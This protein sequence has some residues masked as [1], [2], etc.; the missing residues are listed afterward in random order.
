MLRF[1][2][3]LVGRPI[4]NRARRLAVEF[5]QQTKRA[6]AFQRE[7]LLSRIARNADSAFGR[8]H[9][10]GE[11]HS[12]EDFRR[13]VPIADYTRHEPYIDRVRNGDVS[14]LFGPGTEVLMF[15]MTSGTTNRPKTI[16]VTREALNNY[17]EGWLIWGIQAFDAH[18]D[19]IENG[20]RPILQIASDWRESYTPAGIPC[21]AI[22]GLTASMQSRMIRTTYCMP[23][24]GSRIK[25]VESKYYVALR[26]SIYK[27]L[28][29]IIAA[30]PSTILN[31]V[32]LGDRERETLIR[33]LHDGT[34]ATRWSIPDDVRRELRFRTRIRR[35]DAA[36][37]LEQIVS[38]TGR[39]LPKDYWPNLEFL[40]NWMGG[41][42]RAYLRG[43]PEF[44]GEKPVRDVGL[45]AS[46]G[47]MTIPIEDNTPAGVLDIRHHYFEFIPEEDADKPDPQ[48]VE[49]VDL[50]EGKNYFV[51]LT[52]AGGLYRY[53][54]FDL[55]R[56]V[57]FHGEAPIVE[58]LNKGAHFSS[59]TGEK[60]SE[61]QVITAVESAQRSVGLRLRSYLLLPIWGDPPSYGIL[62]EASDLPE[63]EAADRFTAEVEE[64]LRTL[65]VEYAAKRDS[66]RLGPV[67]TIRI[68]DGAWGEFQKR[69]LAR[70]GGTVE[71]YKQPHLIPDVEAIHA[72][73]TVAT[74][75]S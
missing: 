43:Y 10:F 72:F 53:N 37:R 16:P 68:R 54:I 65:N 5:H 60:L 52:T 71:Q 8:D 51:L 22:T 12:P 38:E 35:K 47:R 39:L 23:P 48:T 62:V 41:T 64:Q 70:S 7:L 73:P 49:A 50:V 74:I 27:N 31:M 57:G 75:G 6:G 40:S 56:C 21:G 32:R 17:R 44:F 66:L 59:L 1:I 24:S 25:D 69:R 19:I 14:A 11:I 4:A 13:Q 58:F 34:L 61:H 15:A 46:E 67:R 33:D 26:Y 28:G 30:N 18:P 2:K 55:V 20:L 45:I 36:R 3:R 29:T 42:M 63:G 9:H